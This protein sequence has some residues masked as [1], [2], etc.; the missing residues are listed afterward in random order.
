[1]SFDASSRMNEA[2]VTK[3]CGPL[4]GN[5]SKYD[6]EDSASPRSD[7]LLS[8]LQGLVRSHLDGE[9]FEVA[10]VQEKMADYQSA[11]WMVAIPGLVFAGITVVSLLPLWV[12]RCCAHKCCPHKRTA[13][14]GK[15]KAAAGG[16]CGLWGL[17]T[18][19]CQHG[20]ARAS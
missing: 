5:I 16:C 9:D 14:G 6:L 18:I 20:D 19:V 13:Y 7:A 17:V 11:L 10:A 3:T 15:H 12:S 2:W 4:I 8:G 1:M